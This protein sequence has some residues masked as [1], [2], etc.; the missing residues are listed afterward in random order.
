MMNTKVRTSVLTELGDLGAEPGSRSWS[1]AVRDEMRMA[2][3]K[4]AFDSRQFET[5]QRLFVE[6]RG[7]ESLTDKKNHR[8]LSYE[9]FCLADSPHGLGYDLDAINRIVAERKSAE[10][11]AAKAEP[12]NGHGGDR[13]EPKG[14]G[15]NVTLPTRGN[16]SEYLT[17]RIARDRP[18]ILERMK[19]GEFKSVRKA[20]IEAG[21]V[22]VPTAV[23][24]IVKATG[25][26]QSDERIETIKKLFAGLP[27]A[28]Q[29]ALR[30]WIVQ[31]LANA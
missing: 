5:Y 11:L 3:D 12:L 27:R 30:N 19:G 2:L 1:I 20:A 28:E 8:F 31:E 17:A 4:A 26:L 15:N 18:D 9:A 25:K 6:H 7:W 22:K 13:S 29:T 24:R 10:A 14:Q 23:E 21:I 16:R